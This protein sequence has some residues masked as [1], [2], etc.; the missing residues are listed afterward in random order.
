MEI[1]AKVDLKPSRLED[2]KYSSYCST[3][4]MNS[5][6]DISTVNLGKQDPIPVIIVYMPGCSI[7]SRTLL[8]Q[9]GKLPLKFTCFAGTSQFNY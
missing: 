9:Q 4:S 7:G 3:V 8:A 5:L 6:A 1:T 2:P